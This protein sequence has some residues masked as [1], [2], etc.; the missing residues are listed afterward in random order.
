MS[1]LD[2]PSTTTERYVIGPDGQRMT[3]D[4]LP[5]PSTQRWVIRRKAEVVA[6]VEGE[7]ISLEDACKRYGISFEEFEGWQKAI[8]RHGIQGLRTT[9][10]KRYREKLAHD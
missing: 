9:Q 6:A 2:T 10:I 3:L 5:P 1:M 7:L 4:M 8:G